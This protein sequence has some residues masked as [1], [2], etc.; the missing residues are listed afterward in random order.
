MDGLDL[1]VPAGGLVGVIGPDGVGQ[2]R[3]LGLIAGERRIQE[4]SVHVLGTDMGR[5]R[6]RRRVARRIA[7]LPQGLGSNLYG[8]LS[9]GENVGFFARL[10]D[11]VRLA[12]L[13]DQVR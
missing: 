10:F 2:S 7:F 3:L 9:V 1:D 11:G 12:L 13:R 8:D 5:P 6:E 4:S